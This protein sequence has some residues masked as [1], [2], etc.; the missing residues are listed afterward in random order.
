[1]D[2]SD[3]EIAIY[4]AMRA[5]AK[6][7]QQKRP[8]GVHVSRVAPNIVVGWPTK[9]SMAP[10]LAEEVFSEAHA[11]LQEPAGY[12]EPAIPWPTP[13]VARYPWEEVEWFTAH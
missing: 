7:A 11:E 5:E 6:T 8:S 1:M 13:A 2:F 4:S 12:E 9:L 10:L 3:V